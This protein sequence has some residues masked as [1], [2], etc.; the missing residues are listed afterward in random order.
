MITKAW[1]I[2]GAEGHR[3]RDS[4]GESSA[5]RTYG[6][7]N[8]VRMF[9]ED[10]LGTNDYVI[11]EITAGNEEACKAEFDAQ[12]IDGIFENSRVGET[13]EIPIED[14]PNFELKEV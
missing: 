8:L 9:R 1:K 3:Q 6:I 4:F 5:F 12:M 11:I 13:V 7:E 10:I 14:V 2:Y